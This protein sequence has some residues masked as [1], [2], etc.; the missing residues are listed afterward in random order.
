MIE[1]VPRYFMLRDRP[2]AEV[3]KG[4]KEATGAT[5]DTEGDDAAIIVE[6]DRYPIGF[7]TDVTLWVDPAQATLPA[8]DEALGLLLA[9]TFDEDVLVPPGPLCLDPPDP[10]EHLM[11]R[12]DGRMFDVFSTDDDYFV[13][14]EDHM[15]EV[16]PA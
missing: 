11:V 4:V 16:T 6:I 2:T 13:L 12:P 3:V 15:R 9:K 14:D 5:V 8:D 1:R 7:R 10:G